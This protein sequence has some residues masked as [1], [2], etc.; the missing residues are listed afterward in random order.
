[1]WSIDWQFMIII[2]I[3]QQFA[4]FHSSTCFSTTTS[5]WISSLRHSPPTSTPNTWSNGRSIVCLCGITQ[6]SR[7]R[8]IVIVDQCSD[9]KGRRKRTIKIMAWSCNCSHRC[10][11][12]Q[13]ARISQN[14]YELFG[15]SIRKTSGI[16]RWFICQGE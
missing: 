6:P 7:F 16:L 10:S 4:N 11:W 9:G 1:M 14:S 5:T 3:W 13:E 2:K 8:H 12:L 15:K